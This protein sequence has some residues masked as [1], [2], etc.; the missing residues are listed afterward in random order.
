MYTRLCTARAAFSGQARP[1]WPSPG[2]SHQPVTP[3]GGGGGGYAFV[4]GACH[5][6]CGTVAATLG[7]LR[8]G[9]GSGVRLRSDSSSP[10]PVSPCPFASGHPSPRSYS[11]AITKWPARQAWALQEQSAFASAPAR[12]QDFVVPPRVAAQRPA[13]TPGARQCVH[14]ASKEPKYG[15]NCGLLLF[16]SGSNLRERSQHTYGYIIGL[17]RG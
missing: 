3:W 17:I 12:A 2:E 9:V 5:T 6:H 10:L 4:C 13:L 8:F 16:C 15:L 1:L 7:H 11:T 14:T